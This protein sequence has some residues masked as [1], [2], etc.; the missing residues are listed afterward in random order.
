MRYDTEPDFLTQA[1]LSE[2]LDAFRAGP[3]TIES[4]MTGGLLALQVHPRFGGLF[5]NDRRRHE[6]F[7]YLK[8]ISKPVNRRVYSHWQV[9]RICWQWGTPAQHDFYLPQLAASKRIGVNANRAKELYTAIDGDACY[10]T[11][12]GVQAVPIPDNA[13]LLMEGWSSYEQRYYIAV[14]ATALSSIRKSGRGN[15][16]WSITKGIVPLHAVFFWQ[17]GEPQPS[18]EKWEAIRWKTDQSA[19]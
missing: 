13:I 14:P 1:E 18:T 17:G 11:G 7:K 3:Q 5:V 19:S 8:E 9:C 16:V 4:V 15:Y 10:V 6:V 2:R 12:W